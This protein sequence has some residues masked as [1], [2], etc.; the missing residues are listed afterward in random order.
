MVCPARVHR[1]PLIIAA[2]WS[3][4]QLVVLTDCLHKTNL[5]WLV[6]ARRSLTGAF[7]VPLQN[8]V[9]RTRF[10]DVSDR[11]AVLCGLDSCR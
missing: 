1:W 2:M 10:R 5:S 8:L 4:P 6:I 9:S 3:E 7:T 11:T